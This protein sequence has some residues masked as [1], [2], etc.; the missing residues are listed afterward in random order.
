MKFHVIAPTRAPKIT[1]WSTMETS[2]IPLPMVAATLRWKTQIATMLKNAAN[3]TAVC[4]LST[5]VETTVA[6]EFA[7]SWKPFMKSNSTARTTSSTMKPK[8]MSIACIQAAIRS[9]SGDGASA[10]AAGRLSSRVLQN[11][12]FDHVGD[13]LAAVG[14]GLEV[15]VDGLELDQLA[16]LDVVAEQ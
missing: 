8:P 15:L 3:S 13:I 10:K 16:C 11:D 1:C 9:E 7:A 5:P 12:A 6:I 4:G 14:D 2:T